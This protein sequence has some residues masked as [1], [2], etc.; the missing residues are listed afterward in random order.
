MIVTSNNDNN[1]D[2]NI[3]IGVS[4]FTFCFYFKSVMIVTSNNANND[5]NDDHNNID[6]GVSSF[7]FYCI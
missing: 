4:S 1:D 2:N 6:I 5:S 3:D 7:A